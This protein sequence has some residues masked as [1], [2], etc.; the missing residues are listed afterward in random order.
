MASRPQTRNERTA[1]FACLRVSATGAR[2][3]SV[4]R[5]CDSAIDGVLRRRG[6]APALR[7][8]RATVGVA[9]AQDAGRV[10]SSRARSLAGRRGGSLAL[11]QDAAQDLARGRLWDLLDKLDD[12]DLLVGRHT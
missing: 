3:R 9:R 5:H 7:R 12:A 8:C 11:D 2:L 1:A 10:A 4:L 6:V